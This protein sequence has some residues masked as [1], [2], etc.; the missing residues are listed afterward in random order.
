[1]PRLLWLG[2]WA[3]CICGA[4]AQEPLSLTSRAETGWT[5]NATETP[6]GPADFFAEH[7][8]E[9]SLSGAMGP[10][11]L[12]GTLMFEQTRFATVSVEDDMAATGGIEAA[13]SLAPGMTLRAGYAVTYDWTGEGLLLGTDLVGLNS[14]ALTQ[15]ALVELIVA[16]Q[17]QQVT[18]RVDASWLYPGKTSISGLPAAVPPM[19]LEPQVTAVSVTTDW[20]KAVSSNVAA[21]LHFGSGFATIPDLDQYEFGRLS[22]ISATA[23]AG[24][25]LKFDRIAIEALGGASLVWPVAD[26]GLR[27]SLPYAVVKAEWGVSDQFSL[28]ARVENSVELDS[29]L[30]PVADALLEAELSARYAVSEAAALS[31]AVVRSEQRGL[32]DLT[33]MQRQYSASAGFEYGVSERAGLS[34]AAQHKWVEEPGAN[35]QASTIRLAVT[36]VL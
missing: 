19:R 11:A 23:G 20:E 34:L 29:P 28:A 22:A 9:L 1:M 10:L 2:L 15:E 32:F 21:L 30:D 4:T 12:R 36:M 27:R 31:L 17:D 13:L 33:Q 7:S 8:H 14:T 35:Y 26:P 18:A 3:V 5:S 6:D 24:A 25:R 16:G